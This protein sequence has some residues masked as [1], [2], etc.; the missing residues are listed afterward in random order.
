M[1]TANNERTYDRRRR[2]KSGTT[3]APDSMSES[4]S[5]RDAEQDAGVRFERS[6]LE[7]VIE[8]PDLVGQVECELESMFSLKDHRA[9]WRAVIELHGEGLRPDLPLLSEKSKVDP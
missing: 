3:I 5:V 4:E 6:V 2:Q 7:C 8:K 1:A 9:I